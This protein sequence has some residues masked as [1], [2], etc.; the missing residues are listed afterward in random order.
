MNEENKKILI[1]GTNKELKFE[2]GYQLVS[3]TKKFQIIPI[4]AKEITEE[5]Q[6]LNEDFLIFLIEI[7][8][9]S[10]FELFLQHL[11]TLNI[12]EFIGKS[13]VVLIQTKNQ[14]SKAFQ[15]EELIRITNYFRI[16]LFH[17]NGLKENLNQNLILDQEVFSQLISYIEI[18]LHSLHTREIWVRFPSD[19]LIY[20]LF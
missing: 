20:F 18:C 19:Q 16:P 13:S 9:S 6:E 1:T 11:L 14:V 2:F 17:I 10:S 3:K 8:D 5:L 7:S 15:I 4:F 12:K